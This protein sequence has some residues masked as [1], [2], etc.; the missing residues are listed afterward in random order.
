MT[1]EEADTMI[2]D[3][4][5]RESRLGDWARGFVDSVKSQRAAG[6]TLTEKQAD[7]LESIWNKATEKG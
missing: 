5:N 4:E 6:K 1:N 3:C 7:T 2:E